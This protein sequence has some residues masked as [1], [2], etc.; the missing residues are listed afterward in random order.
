[1]VRRTRHENCPCMSHQEGPPRPS[2]SRRLRFAIPLAV[3]AGLGLPVSVVA[4]QQASETSSPAPPPARPPQ[5]AP[6]PASRAAA[7][8]TTGAPALPATQGAVAHPPSPLPL[9]RVSG[10][11]PR[12]DGDEHDDQ[13]ALSHD[14]DPGTAWFTEGFATSDFAKRKPGVG[15]AV[16]LGSVRSVS[17]VRL[18]LAGGGVGI[19]L[20]AA[21]EPSDSDQGYQ[22]VG[23][24]EDAPRNLTVR[25]AGTRARYWLVEIVRLARL[26]AAGEDGHPYPYRAGIAEMSFLGT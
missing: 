18:I 2:H 23:A 14:G 16:D 3:V 19:Q 20:R 15:L 24:V 11:D 5:A 26:P 10:W 17:A 13:V 8:E 6:L 22:L 25:P 4:F 21:D 9:A 12:P 1:M 7:P